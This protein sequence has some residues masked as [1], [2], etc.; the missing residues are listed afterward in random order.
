VHFELMSFVLSRARSAARSA[1]VISRRTL[2]FTFTR[3]GAEHLQAADLHIIIDSILEHC[4]R[5]TRFVPLLVLQRRT[6]IV[7]FKCEA[8]AVEL[9]VEIERVYLVMNLV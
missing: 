9:K 1:L 4:D 3:A 6:Q 7:H 5:L 8:N 2:T